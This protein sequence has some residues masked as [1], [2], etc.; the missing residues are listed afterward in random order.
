MACGSLCYGVE[1]IMVS[2]GAV[3][4]ENLLASVASSK[5][6]KNAF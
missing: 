1:N 6:L 4:R 3:G 5:R 2:Q